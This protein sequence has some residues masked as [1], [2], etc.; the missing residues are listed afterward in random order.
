MPAGGLTGCGSHTATAVP[1]EARGY[2]YIYNGG[3]SGTCTGI[4]IVKIKIC[5]LTNAVDEPARRRRRQ[6]Q[7]TPS[8]STGRTATPSCAGG[9]GNSIFRFDMTRSVRPPRAAS[10]SRC[11]LVEQVPDVSIGHSAAFPTTARPS[12]SA[13]S[14]AAAHPP[15][16]GDDPILERTLFFMDTETGD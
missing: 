6:R 7:T 9:N 15:V 1:D 10:R 8:A 12:S 2:L 4:D 11:D 16:R 14:R 13:G 5:D 3:S